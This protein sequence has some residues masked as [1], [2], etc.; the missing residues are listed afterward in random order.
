MEEPGTAPAWSADGGTA[1]AWA[2]VFLFALVCAIG[3]TVV[4]DQAVRRVLH[5]LV[6]LVSVGAV[7]VGVARRRPARRIPWLLMAPAMLILSIGTILAS[8]YSSTDTGAAASAL[9]TSQVIG[10]PMMFWGLLQFGRTGRKA[11]ELDGLLDALILAAAF[12]LLTWRVALSDPV[13]TSDIATA[14]LLLASSLPVLDIV[15]VVVIG[16]RVLSAAQTPVALRLILGGL[17]VMS[18]NH[19]ISSLAVVNSVAVVNHGLI[20]GIAF[21]LYGAAAL[22]PS[23]RWVT[24][25]DSHGPERFGA[26]RIGVLALALLDTPFL[27]LLDRIRGA[28]DVDYSLLA[29]ST[30][31]SGIV[32]VRL[33][34]LARAAE[35]AGSRERASQQRFRSLVQNSSDLLAVIE[36]GGEVDFVSPAIE[37]LLGYRADQARRL[38]LASVCEPGDLRRAQS[39]LA[40]L[41]E[42]GVSDLMLVRLRHRS[43]QW[44]WLEARLVNLAGDPTIGGTV[45][46]GRDVT[47]RVLAERSLARTG[48]QQ[49]AVAQL[50]REALVATEVGEIAETTA[51]LVRSTIDAADTML[52]LTQ[53]DGPSQVILVHDGRVDRREVDDPEAYPLVAACLHHSGPMHLVDVSRDQPLESL[54]LEKFSPFDERS[55]VDLD[56]VV[57]GDTGAVLGVPV[58]DQQGAIGVILVRVVDRRSF[59]TAEAEFVDTMAQ[60]LGLAIRRRRAEDTAQH[61]ALHDSLT[62]LPNRALFVDRLTHAIGQIDRSKKP[63]AVAFLDIDHFKVVND[64]LGHSAGDRILTETA[65]RLDA[66]LRPG[67]TVAR[68]GGDE[69]TLLLDGVGDAAEALEIG[70]RI[71]EELARPITYGGAHLHTTVSIGLAVSNDYTANAESMLRDADAA[72]YRAKERGRDRVVIFDD[73]MRDHAINRLRTE[74]DLRRALQRDELR[75][76]YQPVVDLSNGT[77]MG[78][79]ALVRWDHPHAGLILPSDFIPIAEQSGLIADLGAWVMQE[80]MIQSARWT[81]ETPVGAVTPVVSLN[82]SARSLATP[83]LEEIVDAALRTSGARPD[84]ICLEI[85]ESALMEDVENSMRTLRRLKDLGLTLA[86]DD[87]GTGYSSLTYLKRFTVDLVKIDASFI[88]G[89]GSDPADAAIVAAVDTLAVTLGRLTIAEG[90]EDRAHLLELRRLGCPMGQ[91]FLLGRP[92]PPTEVEL[93]KTIDLDTLA[94]AEKDRR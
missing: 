77:V 5:G 11:I 6:A 57:V 83:G 80:A 29:G 14:R 92:V 9:Q 52:V 19:V 85:T 66:V 13:A 49:R 68:F 91:G 65:R 61:Q 31:I 18:V 7:C 1:P 54:P 20:Q 4:P 70:E 62:R 76:Y 28:E 36:P 26:V 69:F 16:R 47:D 60:T 51:L 3:G 23:M 59:T 35:I 37:Q 63:V 45:V 94:G 43:G 64:S 67:D 24:E 15:L 56:P 42:G 79:E 48:V 40:E 81:E 21:S 89:L 8:W 78:Y 84:R 39:V 44:R 71:R 87:F 88:A 25:P 38:S 72:M 12:G 74:L 46:N 22:H 86:I 50:G 73:T 33:I 30:V 2:L 58:T 41:P 32:V 75:L 55:S 82:V 90:V 10:F 53:T 93:G 27:L 34:T 17:V